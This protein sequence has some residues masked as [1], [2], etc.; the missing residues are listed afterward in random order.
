MNPAEIKKIIERIDTLR[1][2]Q[3]PLF[4]RMNAHQM[5]CHCTDQFRLAMGTKVALEYGKVSTVKI[6]L[7]AKTG[8]TVPTPKGFGQVEGEG[9]APSDFETDKR[10]LKEHLL[11]YS[12]LD[13]D[14][15]YPPHPY[16]G[17]INKKRW[18]DLVVYH[19]D[20]HLGQFGV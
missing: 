4:G 14:F 1:P 9:T 12:N 13:D 15:D 3:K 5:I 8:K 19:L 18:N 7:L 10:I 17:K 20:H 16:F 2:D 6:M 11:K